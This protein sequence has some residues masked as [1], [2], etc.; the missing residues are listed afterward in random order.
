[1]AKCSCGHSVNLNGDLTLIPMP[2]FE[3]VA[4]YV[5]DRIENDLS[6]RDGGHR[7]DVHIEV[8][9]FG[10]H[11]SGEPYEELGKDNIGGNDV[12]LITSGPGT[13]KM[14]CQLWVA[15]CYLKGRRA[16]RIA[17]VSG[18]YPLSRSEKDEGRLI[19]SLVRFITDM[20][21]AASY[22]KL[23][24]IIAVDLHSDG[25]VNAGVPGLV[26][27]VSAVR[28]LLTAAVKDATQKGRQLT[29][30]FPDD[31]ARKRIEN[32]AAAVEQQFDI[33]LP[34]VFGS[35]R[36]DSSSSSDLKGLHGDMDCLSG[37]TVLVIDDEIAGG[38]TMIQTAKKL[39]SEFDVIEVWGAV[40]H[41][42]FTASAYDRF[43]HPE[44]PVERVYT[45]DTI[46]LVTR[47]Q[48]MEMVDAGKIIEV[49]WKNDLSWIV[50]MHHEDRTIR[51]A[52]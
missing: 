46:P 26:T 27:Q 39:I 11:P 24:R 48:V 44:C 1:M 49:S 40:T 50:Y 12:V 41:P 15:L 45:A 5:K 34:Q 52:R 47:P 20:T 4:K 31:S 33:V 18:Y 23:D 32:A 10:E 36:R 19:L 21:V 3:D 9:V 42:V 30:C 29:L 28:R 8:P 25:A 6:L 43:M 17:V 13:Y 16:R 14:L 51:E 35:K 38:G 2:G 22:G 7:T 37:A